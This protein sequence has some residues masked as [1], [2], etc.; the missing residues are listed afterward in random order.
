MAIPLAY[1]LRSLAVR[2]SATALSALGIALTVAVFGGVF[3]LRK[4]FRDLYR[5]RGE[6]S[7]AIYLRRGATSEGESG[8]Q[9]EDVEILIKERPEI[10]RDTSGEPL[11]AAESYLAVYM[12]LTLGGRTNVPLRGVQPQSIALHGDRFRLVEGRVIQFGADEVMVGQRLTERIRDCQFG[13]TI[14]LNTTE[15]R[16]VGVFDI[17]GAEGSE[18]WGDANRMLDALDRPIFQRVV[19]RVNPGTDFE[20][21]NRSLD[22]E[23]RM[24]VKAMSEQEYLAGQSSGLGIALDYLGTFLTAIMSVASITGAMNT[25]LAAVAGRTHEIGILLALGY[26]RVSVFLAFLLESVVLGAAGGIAGILLLLPLDGLRT[27]AM[28]FNTFTDVSFAFTVTPQEMSVAFAIAIATGVVGGVV[29]AAI[30]ASRKP[31]N[32]LRMA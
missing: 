32:A 18:I 7:L 6:E 2:R 31:V 30:A 5:P 28:N 25:M 4:G 24:S 16:V 27:G 23:K 13:G 22:L 26:S 12:D 19:A 20:A 15:F 3:A 1:S 17:A 10:A 11:A 8:L 21:V 14:R 9:R 29:P